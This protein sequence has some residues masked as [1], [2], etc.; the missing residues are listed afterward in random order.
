MQDDAFFSAFAQATQAAIKTHQQEKLEALRNAVLNVAVGNAP[1]EDLQCIFLNLIDS[2]TSKH[3][4]ILSFFTDRNPVLP[5]R[6]QIQQDLT[7]QL[8][9]ELNSR[10]LIKDP[11]PNEARGKDSPI[12]LINCT[13]QV[14]ALGKQFLDFI[15][16]PEIERA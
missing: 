8:V 14:S 5:P 7:D 6:F 9:T 3:M 16:A 2:F 12:P 11:R 1:S 13:W 4:Q 15:K 10:G